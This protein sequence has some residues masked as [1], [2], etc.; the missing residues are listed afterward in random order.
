MKP[1]LAMLF[2]VT[3]GSTPKDD[4]FVELVTRTYEARAAT[5]GRKRNR[6]KNAAKQRQ[7]KK[8][9]GY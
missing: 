1:I 4:A 5:A 7:R 2:D 8:T 6:K 3:G 9:R